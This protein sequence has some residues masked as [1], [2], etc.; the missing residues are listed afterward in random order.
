[1]LKH[2]ALQTSRWDVCRDAAGCWVRAG[3]VKQELIQGFLDR[4][5]MILDIAYDAGGNRLILY[6]GSKVEEIVLEWE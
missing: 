3:R 6:C 4:N 2:K 1:M 5:G